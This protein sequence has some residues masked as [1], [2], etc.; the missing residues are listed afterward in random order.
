[1]TSMKIGD[2]ILLLAWGNVI[3]PVVSWLSRLSGIGP[4]ELY[5]MAL[6][7]VKSASP[8]RPIMNFLR[9]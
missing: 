9:A 4:R 8:N 7:T 2:I 5:D 6:G 1:M 3:N